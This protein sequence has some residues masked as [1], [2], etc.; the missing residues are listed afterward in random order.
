MS[1]RA[2]LSDVDPAWYAREGGQRFDPQLLAAARASPLGQRL[3]V[4][5][6]PAAATSVLLAPRPGASAYATLAKRLPRGRL[7]ALVRDLGILAFAPM[8]RA[9]VRREPVRRLRGLLGTGYLLALDATVWDGRMA[10]DAHARLQQEWQALIDDPA[11][12][13]DPVPLGA[14]FD[15]Q[16]RSE[17][18]AWATGRSP[19]LAEWTR[20]VHGDEAPR[21][22]HLPEKA[23]LRV[24]THHENSD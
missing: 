22:A 8:I 16:G 20:L 19:A 11:F 6:L 3:L 9:E 5:A 18:R 12:L 15:R 21:A 17:L 7:A 13:V 4:R 10:R 23:V 14:L 2:L 24:V 1:L